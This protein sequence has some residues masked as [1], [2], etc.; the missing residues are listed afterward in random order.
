MT[1]FRLRL[2]HDFGLSP[3]DGSPAFYLARTP[4]PA[5]QSEAVLAATEFFNP[6]LATGV[7]EAFPLERA[8]VVANLGAERPQTRANA[9]AIL[10][11]AP[12]EETRA[13]LEARQ[14]VETNPQVKLVLA[15]ALVHHG[16][17]SNV[18]ALTAALESCQGPVCTLP[19]MLAQWLPTEVKA[20]LN[21]AVLARIVAGT[22]Y[23]PKAHLFAA[24]V[25]RDLGRAK[26]LDPPTVEALIVAGRRKTPEE[27]KT[28]SVACEAVRNATALS[29]EDVLARLEPGPNV[30]L[31]PDYVS[32]GPM[33]ARL[34]NVA[35]AD[36]L[37]LL[38]R[39]MARFGNQSGPEGELIIEA[40]LRVPGEK[41]DAKL[42]SWL[43]QY[44]NAQMLITIGLVG[45]PSVSRPALGRL[46]AESGAAA[47]I[48]FKALTHAPDAEATLLG[49]LES[50]TLSEKLSAAEVAGLTGQVSARDGLRRLL[51]FSD[52]RYYPNDAVI[53]HIAMEAFDPDR[54]RRDVEARPDGRGP[55]HLN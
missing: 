11:L 50:G 25:L 29:R 24:A 33:L 39:M 20:D 51:T 8:S 13:A 32:P 21:Q 2:R 14:S 48:V 18:A 46:A 35:T 44:P 12:A 6:G 41:A 53:R 28:A 31:A 9:A 30:S 52:A 34:G 54:H 42:M 3:K 45:R 23:E 38:G 7:A 15:Y 4:L 16:V 47:N 36:D 43:H 17:T 55:L 49:Y 37:P 10:A 27:A 1:S 22:S 5:L 40:V 19:V 26:P